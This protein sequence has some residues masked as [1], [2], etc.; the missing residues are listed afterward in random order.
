MPEQV[1]IKKLKENEENPRYI[2]KDKFKK[3]VNSIKEFP[4]M[5][6]QRPIIVD[7][8]YFVLGGNMRLKAC[9]EAGIKKVWI[10]QVDGWTIEQKREF[11]IKDNVGFGEWDWDILGN[12][13]S[14]A[15]L[16]KWGME[17]D[18]FDIEENDM[19]DT[20]TNKID[21]PIYEPT[22]EK[23]KIKDLF[24]YDKTNALIEK[25]NKSK[26]KKAEKDFLINAAYRHITFNYSNIADYYA[27]SSKEMQELMEE[28]ALIIIDF[29]KAIAQG[30]LQLRE[31][32]T[33]Q[34]IE[35]YGEEE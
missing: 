12:E 28:S 34:Y 23:P 9:Q 19:Q 30:Y 10:S 21:A 7:E 16:E 2:N 4:E 32:I 26:L 20:Y 35:E 31:E 1:D 29:E 24:D 14:F 25:I 22:E 17:V 15:E 18:N 8:N 6:E 11:I 3:L 5:L 13:Y 27:H 33:T